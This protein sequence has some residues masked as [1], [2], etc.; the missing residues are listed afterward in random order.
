MRHHQHRA[1]LLKQ[2][3]EILGHLD[4]GCQSLRR[5]DPNLK[6]RDVATMKRQYEWLKELLLEVDMEVVI[7]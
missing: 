2:L 5:Y 3:D 6:K 7:V 4:R 1:D